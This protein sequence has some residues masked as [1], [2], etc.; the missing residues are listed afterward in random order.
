MARIFLHFRALLIIILKVIMYNFTMVFEKLVT[1]HPFFCLCLRS[2]S[3]L[4]IVF[5]DLQFAGRHGDEYEIRGGS[6]DYLKVSGLLNF[7][8]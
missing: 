3:G 2:G 5:A 8:V 1:Y 7:L 6:V 4:G